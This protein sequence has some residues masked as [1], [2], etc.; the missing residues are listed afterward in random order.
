M[1]VSTNLCFCE[2]EN[3]PKK[4]KEKGGGSVKFRWSDPN[5]TCSIIHSSSFSLNLSYFL[6][7][8]HNFFF[9]MV[10]K[11]KYGFCGYQTVQEHPLHSMHIDWISK[12]ETGYCGTTVVYSHPKMTNLPQG[13]VFTLIQRSSHYQTTYFTTS[14]LC[15]TWDTIS[16]SL[17]KITCPFFLPLILFKQS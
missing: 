14:Q 9:Q 12:F 4:R 11:Y 13:V 1:N 6:Q 17:F 2:F 8:V 15:L 10:D 16:S 3:I 5:S 7:S